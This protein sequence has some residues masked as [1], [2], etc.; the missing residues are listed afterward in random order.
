MRPHHRTAATLLATVALLLAG[1]TNASTPE[2]QAESPSPRTS[3]RGEVVFDMG[4]GE[5]FSADDT[6]EMGQSAALAKISEAGFGITVNSDA[7]TSEDLKSATGLILPGPMAPFTAEE[8][9]AIEQFVRR[10]GTVLL[11]IHVPFPVLNV[12]ARWGLPVGT[13]IMMSK[14]PLDPA[15][16]SVFVADQIVD[17][18]LMQGVNGVLVVS[19]WPVG[20]NAQTAK[21]A[22]ATRPDTWLT[23]G[24]D[25]QVAPPADATFTSY[26]VVGVARVGE[27][28][29]IVSGDDAI[30]ANAVLGQAGN[31]QLLKNII[32]LMSDEAAS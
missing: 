21:M 8:D 26:G 31:A 16:P 28:T 32:D 13:E 19:G 5:V 3:P 22:L 2:P 18:P 7:I 12:P 14:S 20:V 17:E 27:G 1:C 10:G 25:Q 29:V 11:T 23:A 6:S 9:A 24:R 30:F 15:Q 4:H